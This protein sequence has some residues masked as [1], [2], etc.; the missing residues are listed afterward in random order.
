MIASYSSTAY[1][2]AEI[3]TTDAEIETTAL[4][5]LMMLLIF[6]LLLQNEISHSR[7]TMSIMV[8]GSNSVGSH[9]WRGGSLTDYPRIIVLTILLLASFA[10][11]DDPV[12]DILTLVGSIFGGVLIF[13]NLGSRAWKKLEIGF[14]DSTNVLSSIIVFFAA[15]SAGIVF[16]FVGLRSVHGGTDVQDAATDVEKIIS[17]PNGKR[18]RQNITGAATFVAFVFLFSDVT[19]VQKSLGFD[20]TKNRACVNLVIGVSDGF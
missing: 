7:L 13:C 16:P 17:N 1:Q 11:L 18:A 14:I 4:H 5:P 3:E 2:N 9:V 10:S 6:G 19:A 20:F 8:R 15:L 12:R